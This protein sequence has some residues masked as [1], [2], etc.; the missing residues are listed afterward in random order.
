MSWQ[1]FDCPINGRHVV[2]RDCV[3]CPFP[4]MELPMV[5]NIWGDGPRT[6]REERYSV[7]IMTKPTKAIV[8]ETLND[9]WSDPFSMVR[10]TFGT[11]FHSV[12]ENSRMT[13]A[14][15]D[16]KDKDFEFERKFEKPLVIGGVPATLVGKADQYQFSTLTLTDY[17]STGTYTYEKA[18]DGD[19]SGYDV[20]LN[21]YRQ[22]LY[23]DAE[24]L[25]LAFWLTDH[26]KRQFVKGIRPFERVTVPFIPDEV[27]DGIVEDKILAIRA[28]LADPESVAPCS[29]EER[30]N[31]N[32]CERWC[33]AAPF[34]DQARL[35]VR[36]D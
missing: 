25:Q 8:L 9:Y 12:M 18:V 29:L 19:Y 24:T 5:V 16:R 2:L 4:C 14:G 33:N 27:L 30:W 26:G 15:F 22:H 7:T 28:G 21:L 17:K 13:L 10:M 1:G 11:L 31:G 35:T 6:K 34:C 32:R 36:H 23:P 3:A 20:Q